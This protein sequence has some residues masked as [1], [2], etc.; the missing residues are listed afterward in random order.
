M[1]TDF[2]DIGQF[3]KFM[4]ENGPFDVI[5][6]AAT[7]VGGIQFG[8]AHAAE[9]YYNNALMHANLFQVAHE[10]HVKRIINPISNCS[11]PSDISEA[12]REENWWQ[13]ELDESVMVYGFI[14]KGSWMQSW[15]YWKQY[16][17]ETINLIVPNMYGPD[18]HFEEV[19]SHALGALV[20][21]IA[22][23]KQAKEPEIIVWGSGEPIREWLYVDDCVEAMMRAVNLPHTEKPINI[24]VGYGVS[25]LELAEMI[26]KEL[27]YTGKLTPDTSKPDGAPYKVMDIER[28]RQLCGWVPS[29]SLN[30]GLR[31][32]ID[33]YL[34]N[35]ILV[36]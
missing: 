21:K 23:A 9:L 31:Q 36:K 15:G 12:F 13:G 2:R 5:L 25:I 7:Y 32:T 16:G 11:Y 30:D 26:Q 1:G 18:D 24:G 27:G 22:R 35:H 17:L 14:R 6:H 34:N 4:Q 8:Y 29:T 10:F 33:W 20:M 19:R 3:R 28:C